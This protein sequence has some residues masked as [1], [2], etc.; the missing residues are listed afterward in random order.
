[1]IGG[2]NRGLPFVLG[3]DSLVSSPGLRSVRYPFAGAFK[4]FL[5]YGRYP[6]NVRVYANASSGHAGFTLFS[7]KLPAFMC[8][9]M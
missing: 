5:Q 8:A 7:A 3:F 9:V 4:D 1:M 2:K 6:A